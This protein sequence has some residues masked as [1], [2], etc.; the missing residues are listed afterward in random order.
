MSV[1][2]RKFSVSPD[3]QSYG[4]FWDRILPPGALTWCNEG[5]G[6]HSG[7]HPAEPSPA[8]QAPWHTAVAIS[9]LDWLHHTVTYARLGTCRG[10]L[11]SVSALGWGRQRLATTWRGF[12]G[13]AGQ[14]GLGGG[15]ARGC[16]SW[17]LLCSEGQV[18]YLEKRGL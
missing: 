14:D 3:A 12:Q 2:K 1:G 9:L 15:R 5:V 11:S 8:L 17:C 6:S 18:L 13:Q 16:C 4:V 10:T 7:H